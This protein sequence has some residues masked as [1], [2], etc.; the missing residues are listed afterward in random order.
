LGTLAGHF[1]PRPEIWAGLAL[2]VGAALL[3]WWRAPALKVQAI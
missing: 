3:T 2:I 1:Q